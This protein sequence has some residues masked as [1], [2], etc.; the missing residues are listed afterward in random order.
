MGRIDG[1]NFD[2]KDLHTPEGFKEYKEQLK[3]SIDIVNKNKAAKKTSHKKKRA[4]DG[5]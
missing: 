3:K 1:W 4:I 2:V 5:K